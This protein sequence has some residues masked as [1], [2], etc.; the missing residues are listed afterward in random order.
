[1]ITDI[2]ST[3]PGFQTSVNIAFDLNNGEKI[4]QLIPTKA[5]VDLFEDLL[6]STADSS[7]KRARI[8]IGAYG[9]GKSHILLSILSFLCRKKPEDNATL[10]E[11]AREKDPRLYDAALEYI[12]SNKRLLPVIINGN[13]TSLIQSFLGALYNT[14][15]QNEL[16]H[17]MPDTHFQAALNTIS[18]WRE[19]YPDTYL[20]FQ[21]EISMPV[22]EFEDRLR[23][24]HVETYSAFEKI[25]PGLTAGSSF[26]PFANFDVVELYA[27]VVEKLP[28]AGYTGIIVIYDEFSKYLESSITTA[29]ISDIKM[30]QDF[31]EKC[32]R[33]GSQQ[34][35][36]ILVSHKELENYIDVLPKQKVDGWKGVSER[37]A[38]VHV[39]S[40]FSQ[41]YEVVSQTIQREP[42][43]WSAYYQEHGQQFEDLK[44][45]F[46]PTALFSDCD[47]EELNTAIVGCYP[48]HPITTFMLPR[49]SEKVAQNERTLF[50]FLSGQEPTSLF[51][52]LKTL[53]SSFPL[54]SPDR[55]YDYF[56]PQ[57]RVEPYTSEIHRLYQLSQGILAKLQ[58]ASL[59]AKIIK[60]VTL[61]YCLGQFE[62][63]TPTEDVLIHI[64]GGEDITAEQVHTAIM[65]LV[66]KE[67]VIYL[68][69][70]NAFLKM[71]ESSGVDIY[72]AIQDVSQKRAAH[73]R[74]SDLL[75]A[76]APEP[77]VYP[78]RYNDQR[79]ITRFFQF[80]FLE[81]GQLS[82]SS[83]DQTADVFP[84]D[85][86]VYCILPSGD[87]DLTSLRRVVSEKS[88][89]TE[90]AVFVLPLQR[91]D[92][93]EQLHTLDAV[94][95][96]RE[97]ARG[98]DL[99][100]DEYDIIYQD[101]SE[102]VHRFISQYTHPEKHAAEYFYHGVTRPL[103]R[104]ANLSALLSEICDKVYAKTPV[105]NNEVLNK[106]HLSTVAV[107][108]R[109]KVIAGLLSSPL[110]Y[111]L[112]LHG[113]GQ[114]VS[115][116]RSTLIT[117]GILQQEGE[118]TVQ[119]NLQPADPSL[120]NVL[121][122]MQSFLIE[123]QQSGAQFFSQ[124]YYKLTSPSFGIG[125]RRGIIPIYLAAVLQH[126][127]SSLSIRDQFQERDLT[128]TLIN[129]IDAAPA[130]FSVE[131][132]DWSDEKQVYLQ[133]LEELFSDFIFQS[134]KSN[135]GYSY[136]VLAL[137]R[138]YLS[139]PNYAKGLTKEYQGRSASPTFVSVDPAMLRFVK[140]LKLLSAGSFELLFSRIPQCFGLEDRP[141]EAIDFIGR[142]K[143][144]FEQAKT[145][146]IHLLA[147]DIRQIFCPVFQ[148]GTSLY[149]ALVDWYDSL[150]PQSKAQ[151]YS[152]GAERIFPVIAN[153]SHNDE[154]TVDT[155]AKA[156]TGLHIDDW[157]EGNI[158]A[159]LERLA[160]YKKTIDEAHRQD[161]GASDAPL[162]SQED[163]YSVVFV[164]ESGNC[165]KKSFERIA[166]S[167][168]S[169]ALYN[170]ID[171]AIRE[172]GQSIPPQEKR[173]VLMEI[174]E[175]LC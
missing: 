65:D 29:S 147:E 126:Y 56:A 18:L 8:L 69:R 85:G 46:R 143:N 151:L 138:W 131:L 109:T 82:E 1:M 7:T 100:F 3:T 53:D 64:Y 23:D 19:S 171:N 155:M 9:K 122:V 140:L 57:M 98:D 160:S 31:A 101:L 21:E 108:S 153:A 139:L 175:K 133:R 117:S 68:K 157:N 45:R 81:S 48:L 124:L 148:Q 95:F 162:S 112:G 13:S 41:V 20:K 163:Q 14:L 54:V 66:H 105:I 83:P 132:F 78:I 76:V 51:G 70:S 165:S 123:T 71:K 12:R 60:T 161:Q 73:F 92:I 17:I 142:T 87:E 91:A 42:A 119:I 154:L 88:L 129:Q 61:I 168:R 55:L 75:N 84:A 128:P 10:L 134:D 152:N 6:L 114:E 120:S 127:Q 90:R 106:N 146:L 99:L 110:Q 115:F 141:L 172:M 145:S 174:L 5:A 118:R 125:L 24:F 4:R 159:F 121:Q 30:L 77:Y 149:S 79:N 34:L 173:Q 89:Q 37:F 33:S 67:Y 72:Q 15:N 40:D 2:I 44:G 111:N 103:H 113:T 59:Q 96:L 97:A 130:S 27:K 137:N 136:L 164:D 28:A 93:R 80:V 86:V 47:E 49:I 39:H 25:Y 32:S 102:V 11:K 135:A 74:D 43:G 50:T 116:L 58:D 26:N 94:Q 52:V 169:N 35:H 63:L 22:K 167:K 170:R 166:R 36:L 107:N 150:S 158:S 62:R 16:R 104:K 144:Y 38:H 156:V